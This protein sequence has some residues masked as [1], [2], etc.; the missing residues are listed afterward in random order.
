MPVS[1]EELAAKIEQEFQPIE[2]QIIDTSDGC[3]QSFQVLIVS[4]A[5]EG[6]SLIQRHRLLIWNY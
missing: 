1:K 5:F 2:K 6:K 3:G 4:K